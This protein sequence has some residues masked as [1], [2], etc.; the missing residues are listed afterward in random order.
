MFVDEDKIIKGNE[1]KDV[2]H[3]AHVEDRVGEAILC[4]I[5][6]DNGIPFMK[7]DRS[8]GLATSIIAG[9]SVFGVDFYVSRDRLD[10]AKELY[11]AFLSGAAIIDDNTENE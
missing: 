5:L 2:A 8:A 6:R 3:L 4:D 7:K 10:E 11:E 9:F 1:S